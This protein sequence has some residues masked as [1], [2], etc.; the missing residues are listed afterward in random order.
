MTS[1]TFRVVSRGLQPGYP[2]EL[3]ETQLAALFKCDKERITP[4]L[5]DKPVTVKKGLR[6]DEAR[7]YAQAL[8]RCGCVCA[9]EPESAAP[10]DQEQ[11]MSVLPVLRRA[12]PHQP[13]TDPAV[14]QP[15]AGDLDIIFQTGPDK[16]I[17]SRARLEASMMSVERLYEIALWNLYTRLQPRLRF[18]QMVNER[19][20][21]SV[22]ARYFHY[23]EAGESH[24]AA[25]LLLWP[26]WKT[27][28]ESLDGPLQI[29][30]PNAQT[31][32]YCSAGDELAFTMMSDIAGETWAESGAGA[33]SG[34]IFTIDA[35][36]KLSVVEGA[37]LL[38]RAPPPGM[39]IRPSAQ[40]VQPLQQALAGNPA[41]LALSEERLRRLQPQLFD[42]TPASGQAARDSWKE[43]IRK[44]LAR[45]DSRA[46]V[47][48][49]AARGIVASYTD[50]LDCAVLLKF[51]P[52]LAQAH[53]W[54]D[55]ARLLAV[56]AYFGRDEGIAPDLEPGPEDCGRWGN[57]WPLIA[58]L[59][60]EDQAGL[61]GRKRDIGEAEWERA[62]QMGRR[63]LALRG[64]ARDGRPL[65][66]ADPAPGLSRASPP[67]ATQAASAAPAR[68]EARRRKP[69]RNKGSFGGCLKDAGIFGLCAW[70]VWGAGRHIGEMPHDGLFYMACFGVLLFSVIGLASLRSAANYLR[71]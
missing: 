45:G 12:A 49:D 29:A 5:A 69:A 56:N 31:C 1:T 50:E 21:G 63:A 58:D 60:T 28:A 17:V 48:L 14:V 25:C 6:E 71:G 27:V 42:L 68:K 4:V 61:A 9:A 59:L 7:K 44:T 47:V 46:A 41:M 37:H 16:A 64:A 8:E 10:L 33:L 23:I 20:D 2:A 54:Q 62:W 39:P 70:A 51:D 22:G 53:G 19:G 43:R 38:R 15:F 40:L 32:L 30:V 18:Q 3:A 34:L 24:E 35:S 13:V 57:V 55:G 52:A 65:G 66:S 26:I 36:G 11:L 67:P